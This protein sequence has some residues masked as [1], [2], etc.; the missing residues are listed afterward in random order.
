[1]I[2]KELE[3]KIRNAVHEDLDGILTCGLHVEWLRQLLS[4][5]DYLRSIKRT[6]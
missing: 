5:I 6:E 4:E 2:D 1:M 3:D